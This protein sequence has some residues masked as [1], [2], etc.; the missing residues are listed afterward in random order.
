[1]GPLLRVALIRISEQEQLI[2]LTIHHII[3]D[4]WSIGI[5][6]TEL[7]SSYEALLR[8]RALRSPRLPVQYRDYV[9]WERERNSSGNLAPQIDYWKG[10]LNGAP[11]YLDL[12]TDRARSASIPWEGTRTSSRSAKSL[13]NP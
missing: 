3:C 9:L 6:F 7:K 10:K 12:P 8:G 2:V 5:F 11:P 13:R 1:V 4:A